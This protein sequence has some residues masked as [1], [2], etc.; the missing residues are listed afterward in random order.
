MFHK[1]FRLAAL[2]AL[3][4]TVFILPQTVLAAGAPDMVVQKIDARDVKCGSSCGGRVD[5][6]IGNLGR[7]LKGGY[8]IFVELKVYEQGQGQRAKTYKQKLFNFPGE[9]S[10]TVTFDDVRVVRCNRPYIFEAKVYVVGGNFREGNTRNND[11]EYK[12]YVRNQCK[13]AN[14]NGGGGGKPSGGTNGGSDEGTG[15]SRPAPRPR[16][17]TGAPAPRGNNGS[18]NGGN[19][20]ASPDLLIGDIEPTLSC[21]PG[22]RGGV[23]D[24]EVK[25]TG[26]ALNGGYNVFVELKVYEQ[27]QGQRARTY[28]EKTFN[29]PAQDSQTFN[30]RNVSVQRCNRPYVFEAKVYV[31][32]GNFREGN[33]RNNQNQVTETIRDTRR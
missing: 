11:L 24:V 16:P 18:N 23:V 13:A 19:N 1:T 26:R 3:L 25:N 4:A 9:S 30:F 8:N 2:C 33:T 21:G 22:S 15:T 32:G 31:V 29:F 5:V 20:G 17:G 7:D 28:K 6:Q 27:G 12:S 10:K 14:E